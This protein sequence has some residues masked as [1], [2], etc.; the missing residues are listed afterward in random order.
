MRS[1]PSQPF[2]ELLA[3]EED[4]SFRVPVVMLVW[5]AGE[6]GERV[7]C[8]GAFGGVWLEPCLAGSGDGS[9]MLLK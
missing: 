8:G 2:L 1:L 6:S 4:P 7:C 9:D 3:G 5:R